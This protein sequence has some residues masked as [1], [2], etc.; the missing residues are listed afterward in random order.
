MKSYWR[1]EANAKG[2]DASNIPSWINTLN[3]RWQWKNQ[4]IYHALS[5]HDGWIKNL[6]VFTKVKQEEYYC[7]VQIRKWA[8]LNILPYILDKREKKVH[9]YIFDRWCN[10]SDFKFRVQIQTIYCGPPFPFPHLLFSVSVYR[11]FTISSLSPSW[12]LGSRTNWK[13][14]LINY[15][16]Q[17]SSGESSGG[18]GG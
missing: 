12:N 1:S 8:N 11:L 6:N 5:S 14:N 2:A 18:G 10:H 16:K 13:H 17:F 15:Y 9:K 7:K 3:H 4:C